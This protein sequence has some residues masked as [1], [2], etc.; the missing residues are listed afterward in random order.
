MV[1]EKEIN[2]QEKEIEVEKEKE[3]EEEPNK[4]ECRKSKREMNKPQYLEDYALK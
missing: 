4:E 3:N 2:D 1:E